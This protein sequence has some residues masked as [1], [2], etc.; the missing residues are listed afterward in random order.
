MSN[1]PTTSM[2]EVLSPTLVQAT[3]ELRTRLVHGELTLDERLVVA[4]V[5]AM[6]V[7]TVDVARD[8]R[9]RVT[10]ITCLAE[11]ADKLAATCAMTL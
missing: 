7:V 8:R 11:R 9:E 1:L 4:E 6:A 3:R 2:P 5:L 10:D